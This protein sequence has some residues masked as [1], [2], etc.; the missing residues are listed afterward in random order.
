MFY[1]K[2]YFYSQIQENLTYIACKDSLRAVLFESDFDSIKIDGHYVKDLVCEERENEII[3]LAHK[4]MSEFF[5]KQRKIFNLPISFKGT[6]LQTKVWQHLQS[7]PFGETQ[8]YKYIAETVNAPK[9]VRAVGASIGKNPLPVIIP[10]HRVISSSGK[11]QGF[12][13]GLPLKQKLLDIEQ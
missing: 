9:A 11:L 8:T 12:L 5:N 13:G 7:I 10:C 1:K 3:I 6:D 2:K 4:Q